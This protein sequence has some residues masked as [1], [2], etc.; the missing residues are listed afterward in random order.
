VAR[1]LIQLRGVGDIEYFP[2]DQALRGRYQ[3]FTEA[4]VG[5]LRAAGYNRPFTSLEEGIARSVEAW[6][7]DLP[8]AKDR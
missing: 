3:S 1:R 8:P 5:R 4:D 6:D 2:F 7:R